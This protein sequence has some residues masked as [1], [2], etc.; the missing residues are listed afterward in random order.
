MP[1]DTRP[2]AIVINTAPDEFVFIGANG[3][4][5][6]SVD[7]PNPSRVA[8]SVMDEGRYENGKWVPGRRIN[9][10]ELFLPALPSSTIGILK[11]Q[12]VR[13]D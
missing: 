12:L 9:G 5:R 10:D 13:L 8:I 6:F 3:S 2:F 11:V 7:S 1:A 4:P